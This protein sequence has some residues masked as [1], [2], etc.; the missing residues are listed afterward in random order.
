MKVVMKTENLEYMCYS[1]RKYYWCPKMY[2]KVIALYLLF[3]IFSIISLLLSFISLSLGYHSSQYWK[4][5]HFLGLQKLFRILGAAKIFSPTVC[6]TVFWNLSRKLNLEKKDKLLY[7]EILWKSCIFI[8]LAF[9]QRM[10]K[11]EFA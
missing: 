8:L 10:C 2:C 6:L 11:N 7:Y 3:F 5:L 1:R 9:I 4:I